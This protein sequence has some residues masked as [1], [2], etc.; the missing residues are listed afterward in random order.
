MTVNVPFAS[1]RRIETAHK[2]MSTNCY[3]SNTQPRPKLGI[4]I[5]HAPLGSCFQFCMLCP[6]PSLHSTLTDW[7]PPPVLL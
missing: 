1:E 4:Q 5:K 3:D 6:P 7:S 2:E